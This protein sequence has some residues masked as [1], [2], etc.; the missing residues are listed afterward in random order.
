[1]CVIELEYFR[2]IFNVEIIVE[3]DINYNYVDIAFN[4]VLLLLLWYFS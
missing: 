2:K 3:V 1:M 4:Y